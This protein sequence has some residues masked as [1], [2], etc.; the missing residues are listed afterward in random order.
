MSKTGKIVRFDVLR[1]EH[2]NRKLCT[3]LYPAYRIDPANRLV[4][5]EVCGGI[6]DPFEAL[7]RLAMQPER[8]TQLIEAKQMELAELDAYKP[9]LRIIK[10][11]EKQSHS[12]MPSCP[13]CGNYFDLCDLRNVGWRSKPK[14]QRQGNAD[15]LPDDG[16]GG[17][18]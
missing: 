2:A 9:R 16:T 4:Y 12:H 3:C 1:I 10:F 5:C 13:V 18:V 7:Y 17:G 8:L 14:P 15:N 11:I 6:V